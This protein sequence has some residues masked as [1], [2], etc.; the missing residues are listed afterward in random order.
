MDNLKLILIIIAGVAIGL[1]ISYMIGNPFAVALI[2]GFKEKVLSIN[3]GG[4]SI[5]SIGSVFS[6]LGGIG[7]AYGWLKS[8]KDA[9]LAQAENAKQV[10]ANTELYEGYSNVTGQLEQANK[11]KDAALQTLDAKTKEFQESASKIAS[12][13]EQVKKL[14]QTVDIYNTETI[15]NLQ[16]QIVEK[17][18]VR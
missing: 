8:K 18:I 7:A 14:R 15:P 12:L 16:R 11:A 17:T 5:G 1:L 6:I 10:L 2:D 13:E 9:A 3:I 4:L